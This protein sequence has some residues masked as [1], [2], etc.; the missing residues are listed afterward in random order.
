MFA[1]RP[2]LLRQRQ[3]QDL[4]CERTDKL[5]PLVILAAVTANAGNLDRLDQVD[6]IELDE[7]T[8]RAQLVILLDEDKV[9]TKQAM[10]TLFKKV[11]NYL[12]FVETGQLKAAAPNASTALRPKI[13]VYGPREATSAEMQNLA[14][15]KLAGQKAGIEVEVQ[16]YQAGI[17]PRP[18][19]IKLVR[20][21][22][23][24]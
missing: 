2:A 12:D 15:L 22:S 14:G 17:K 23:G 6:L 21:S 24:A 19:S 20:R 13:V 9:D 3:L 16:Q 10:K 7:K 18:V 4:Y 11:N 5:I 8:S 1:H